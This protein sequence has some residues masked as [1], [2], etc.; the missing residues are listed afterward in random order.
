MPVLLL[1]AAL[2]VFG[3]VADASAWS[4]GRNGPNSFGTHD[5][6]L[7]EG[8]RLAGRQ[9]RW[10]CLK[11]A[12]RAT[13]DPDTKGGID[14]ASGSWWHVWDEWG[15]TYGG[16][17][18]AVAVWHRRTDRRLARGKRCPASRALGIMAH[19]LGD[20]AQPTHTD[21]DEDEGAVHS[22]YE[23]AVDARCTAGSHWYRARSDGMDRVGPSRRTRA[24]AR[25]SH[26]SYRSLLRAYVRGG[27]TAKVDRITRRQ[28]NRAANA[29]AD[30]IRAL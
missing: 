12:L 23:K 19:M 29:V 2:L 27:Y 21:Q 26:E 7:R 1:L 20:V 13:D 11:P 30:L 10:V 16:A 8:V 15:T 22:G 18:E 28:L 6:I 3:M 25:Q 5:W 24:L 4:N 17:P 14:H 9:G